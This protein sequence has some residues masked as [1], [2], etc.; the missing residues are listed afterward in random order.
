MHR[1]TGDVLNARTPAEVTDALV[2][3]LRDGL[4]LGQVHLSEVSQGGEVGH[5]T[6]AAGDGRRSAT[7]RSSTTAR[8]GSPGSSPPAS[9]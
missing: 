8:P 2:V 1:L 9:R 7:S 3:G 5:A 6:V 4:G